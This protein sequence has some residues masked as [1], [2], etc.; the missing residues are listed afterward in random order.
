MGELCLDTLCIAPERRVE[1]VGDCSGG[2]RAGFLVW[3]DRDDLSGWSGSATAG[4]GDF[5]GDLGTER[6]LV[7]E[8]A[9]GYVEWR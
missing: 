9:T 7:G 4:G 2:G 5:E 8:V 6:E 1:E 3:D